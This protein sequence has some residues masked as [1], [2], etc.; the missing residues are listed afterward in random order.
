MSESREA[1]GAVGAAGG[2]RDRVALGLLALAL[3]VAATRVWRLG[4]WSLWLDEAYT[5]CDA[6]RAEAFRNPIGYWI[7]ARW[8][9]LANGPIDERWLRT[10]ACVFGMLAVPFAAWAFRPLLGPRAA[11]GAALLLAASSWHA[12]WSQTA[13]FYTLAQL[14]SLVGTGLWLRALERGGLVRALLGLA[15]AALAA[16]V[17]PSA[18][19]MLPALVIAPWVLQLVGRRIPPLALPDVARPILRASLVLGLLALIPGVWWGMDVFRRWGMLKG[20]GDPAHF[21]LATG[22]QATP[23]LL[24]GIACVLVLAWLARERRVLLVALTAA[25]FLGLALVLSPFVRVTAQYAFLALPWLCASSAAVLVPGI[26]SLGGSAHGRA[27]AGALYTLLLLP[28][29]AQLGLYHTVRRGERP[30]W[31][32]AYR[33]VYEHRESSD[34]VLGME[35]PVAEFYLGG[36][37]ANPRLPRAVG[38]LDSWRA[39]VPGQWS[40]YP[41]RT[42]FVV[43]PEQ[44]EDWRQPE[45]RAAFEEMLRTDCRLVACWPLYVESRDLSVWV[46]VREP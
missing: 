3:L 4:E 16:L 46:Y 24:A 13:R 26:A 1:P 27:L 18:A 17:H 14:L 25:L 45:L 12:Y 32:D 44:L 37:D 31:R 33:Y 28:A 42:W 36:P 35:A 6:P 19:G 15:I 22:F 30:A 2:A 5:L 10:P 40:R 43:N 8:L 34:L 23:I 7:W 21:V 41:R 39:D 11:A 29:L 38:W 20:G 9:E